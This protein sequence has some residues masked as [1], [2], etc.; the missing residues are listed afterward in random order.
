LNAHLSLHLKS[1]YLFP[2]RRNLL[3]KG[4]QRLQLK[5]RVAERLRDVIRENDAEVGWTGS[6][7]MASTTHTTGTTASWGKNK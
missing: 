7:R 3:S 1:L 4:A 5:K 6:E 2:Q